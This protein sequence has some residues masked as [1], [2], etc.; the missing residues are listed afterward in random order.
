[1]RRQNE[2]LHL[3]AAET[4]FFQRELEQI[5]AENF[6]IKYAELKGMRIVP[7][8]LSVDPGAESWTYSQFDY[9]GKAQRVTDYAK[10]FPSVNASGSQASQKI[11]PFGD[12]YHYT[13][14]E[15]LAAAKV[16]RPLDRMRAKAARDVLA[17]RCD[18]ICA[19]GD[20][21][22]LK[23]IVNLTGTATYAT[24]A[25]AGNKKAW[26]YKTPDEILADM[27]GMI[28]QVV[29][30]TKE[31]ER[32]KRIVLPTDE[33]EYISHTPRSSTSDTTILAYF[34][35]THPEVEVMSW[36]RLSAAGTGASDRAI[37]YDPNPTKVRL[38]LP[39]PF[40]EMP[41]E[42]KNMAYVVNCHMRCGGV[43]APYPKSI[44]YA[45]YIG[46]YES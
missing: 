43:I 29:V 19:S 22:D 37:A 12:S 21:T 9:A 46:N 6:D 8:D 16:G 38:L 17:Q 15:I 7:V 25:G 18:D 39:V 31:V 4:L 40:E 27:T 10:D 45:D 33:F 24:P 28:K 26:K 1:M 36:E 5:S 13:V 3:D 14:Q 23:G 11:V 2:L 35:G 32:P 34:K 20:G 41:P 44:I 30:D 42:R